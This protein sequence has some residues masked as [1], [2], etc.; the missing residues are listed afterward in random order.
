MTRL[1]RDV[2]IPIYWLFVGLAVMVVSPVLSILVSVQ[3][4]NH[5][6]EQAEHAASVA[7]AQAREDARLKTCD[8]FTALLDA[9]VEEPPQTDTGRKV[10]Q[11]YIEF[12]NSP[13]VHCQPP[14]SK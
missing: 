9:Y 1:Q 11:T 3:M 5:N 6:R 12:Y 7:A 8:L 2:H 4:A 13:E 14:R 10:Q